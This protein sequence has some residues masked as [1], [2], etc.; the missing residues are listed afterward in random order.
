MR[1]GT[2]VEVIRY[3]SSWFVRAVD[4]AVKTVVVHVRA[5]H[6]DLSIY[7]IEY[8]PL[9]CTVQLAFESEGGFGRGRILALD[10]CTM[11]DARSARVYPSRHWL[12]QERLAI[13]GPVHL[14]TFVHSTTLFP[15]TLPSTCTLH[16]FGDRA[17]TGSSRTSPELA[18]ISQRSAS[19]GSAPLNRLKIPPGSASQQPCPTSTTPSSPSSPTCSTR[20]RRRSRWSS[21][22]SSSAERSRS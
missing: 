14:L 2:E 1:A 18:S 12:R 21:A 15:S 6:L 4:Q 17:H 11:S 19:R 22:M 20:R 3:I 10:A 8:W 16:K 5:C 7:R 9:G 13:A